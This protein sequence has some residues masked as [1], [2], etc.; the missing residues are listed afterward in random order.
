M[1]SFITFHLYLLFV[2]RAFS[3]EAAVDSS[4]SVLL[5]PFHRFELH[6]E[7]TLQEINEINK[8]EKDQF[9]QELL[10][11][12]T[13]AFETY[14][15]NG[16]R[17]KVLKNEDWQHFTFNSTYEFIQKKSH[18][19]CDLERFTLNDYQELLDE[20]NCTYL[21]VIPWYKIQESKEKVKTK[22]VRRIGLYSNHVIDYDI[23]NRKKEL[24]TYEAS[25]EFHAEAS[26]ENL[27]TKGLMLKD[28][29]P[30]YGVL[31]NE[32]SIELVQKLVE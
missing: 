1:K 21:L 14:N 4:T 7:F 2:L 25:K 6:S 3:Q 30:A 10:Q 12:F 31:V 26:I 13:A 8:L 23:F 20:Y 17:Y 15:R 32:I 16:I 24:V 5:V 9:Y 19:S 18:Y 11:I 28:L 29:A 22:E 27:P